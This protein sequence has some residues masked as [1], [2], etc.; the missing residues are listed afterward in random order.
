MDTKLNR[1]EYAKGY[2]L[3]DGGI[4]LTCVPP[5]EYCCI[6]CRSWHPVCFVEFVEF[7][8]YLVAYC[9]PCYDL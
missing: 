5:V 1:R 6:A 3:P 8:E 9:V 7:N 4:I 2:M